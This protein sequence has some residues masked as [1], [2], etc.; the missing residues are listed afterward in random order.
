[1]IRISK[2]CFISFNAFDWFYCHLQRAEGDLLILEEPFDV[3]KTKMAIPSV[4]Y[5]KT[6]ICASSYF[7]ELLQNA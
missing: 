4:K 7:N 6:K 1:M 5:S 2:I 3:T